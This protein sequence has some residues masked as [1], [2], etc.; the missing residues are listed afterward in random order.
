MRLGGLVMG[1]TRYKLGDLIEQRRE[2]NK[3][4]DVPVR[5]VSRDGFILPKVERVD[6]KTFNVFYLNDFV[7][8]STRMELNS[9]VFNNTY[10][11]GLCSPLYDAFYVTKSEILMP[12]YLNLFVKRS[13]FARRCGKM[14]I[15]S[16]HSKVTVEDLG[17]IEI[18][19]PPLSIQKKYVAIYNALLENQRVYEKGLEDLKLTCDA[20]ID[21]VKHTAP[22]EKLE[23]LIE[24]RREKNKN[25]DVPVRGVSRDGFIDAKQKIAD[26]SSYNV[27]YLN[28]FVFNPARMEINSIAMNTDHE[29]AICSSLYEVFYVKREDL[30]L[31]IFLNMFIKREEFARLCEFIGFGSAREYCRFHNLKDI[32]VPTPTMEVQ[33]SIVAIFNAYMIRREI[34]EQLKKQIK[35][36]CPILIS[37]SNKEAQTK[38][39]YNQR[40]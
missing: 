12:E 21:Q 10:E 30:I 34:N 15:G 18:S 20:Y 16:A 40:N 25:Y 37:G 17:D 31:P 3:D 1:L 35:D 23:T 6:K 11:K 28:D 36:I 13:E 29:K 33:K 2:K 4:Y 27:F 38:E 7:F 8:N 39:Y 26:K 24:Q 9:I 14:A 5:G 22:K 32:K 19:L